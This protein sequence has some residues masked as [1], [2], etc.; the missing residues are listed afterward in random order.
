MNEHEIDKL[1]R[2]AGRGKP[3]DDVW[4]RIKARIEEG[5]PA[6]QPGFDM[7]DALRNFFY[8]FRPVM[9][10]ACVF[11]MLGAAVLVKQNFS[12]KE[13]Y[14]TYVMS[15]EGGNGET[16]SEGIERYFL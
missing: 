7:A 16:I 2:N 3:G 4:L 1:L 6:P 13:P 9:V 15:T 11:V 8:S 12:S 10:M 5:R 14:L